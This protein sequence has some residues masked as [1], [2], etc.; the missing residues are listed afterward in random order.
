MKRLYCQY[1]SVYV[2]FPR[3]FER[4]MKYYPHAVRK[5]NDKVLSRLS[6]K[7]QNNFQKILKRK[8]VKIAYYNDNSPKL[9]SQKSNLFA[10]AK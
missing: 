7:N 4:V 1:L 5:E 9:T 6:R 2:F 8:N 3:I 10:I